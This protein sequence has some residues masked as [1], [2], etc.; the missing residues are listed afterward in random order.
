METVFPGARS[1]GRSVGFGHG[2]PSIQQAPLPG[3][4]RDVIAI[5]DSRNG[6]NINVGFVCQHAMSTQANVSHSIEGCWSLS[7]PLDQDL[8]S[9]SRQWLTLP[10]QASHM[11]GRKRKS[12]IPQMPPQKKSEGVAF[13]PGNISAI[14]DDRCSVLLWFNCVFR[15]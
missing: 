10:S 3:T 7:G 9:E 4:E 15:G 13:L 2:T 1:F 14:G 11:F 5:H 6:L 12:Q 8:P